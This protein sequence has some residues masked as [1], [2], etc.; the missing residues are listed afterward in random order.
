MDL[1]GDGTIALPTSPDK[2]EAAREMS[3]AAH[4]EQEAAE[5]HTACM[6]RCNAELE[7]QVIRSDG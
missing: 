5:K 2:L 7:S 6:Q 1:F 3:D 4:D